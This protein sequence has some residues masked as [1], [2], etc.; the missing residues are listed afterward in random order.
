MKIGLCNGTLKDKLGN[1]VPNGGGKGIC[2][3]FLQS[4]NYLHHLGFKIAGTHFV[5]KACKVLA[6]MRR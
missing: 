6:K 2:R 1:A 3:N 4:V 5:E